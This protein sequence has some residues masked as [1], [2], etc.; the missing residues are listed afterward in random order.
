MECPRCGKILQIK[1]MQDQKS[2]Y[3]EC[4]D[5]RCH[6]RR[7]LKHRVKTDNRYPKTDRNMP[8]WSR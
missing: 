2:E 4:P 6:F 3:A 5:S 8:L 7:T 1:L